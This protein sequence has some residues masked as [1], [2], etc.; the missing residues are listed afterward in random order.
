MPRKLLLIWILVFA[1]FQTQ[2]QNYTPVPGDV[3]GYTSGSFNVTDAGAATYSVPFNFSPGSAGFQPSV[4]MTYSSQ[5]GNGLLGLGWSLQGFSVISRAS[6]TLAQDNQIKGVSFST[7]DRFA[8]DGERLILTDPTNTYGGNGVE[9]RT[10]QNA[11][12]KII[13]FGSSNVP[14]SFKVYTNSGLTIDY[15][16]TSDTRVELAGKTIFWLV[17]KITDTKGNYYTFSYYK[18]NTTGE[19][20]PL[21]IKYTGNTTATVLPYA[22]I[23]FEYED[24]T[25]TTIQYNND[26]KIVGN[27]KRIKTIKNYF[28]NIL[29]R[30]YAFSYQYTNGKISQLNSL[31]ECG[32]NNQCHT[33][34][35]F[36]YTN[37]ET[38]AF[39]SSDVTNIQQSS[40]QEKIFTADIDADG[41]Q[42]ILKINPGNNLSGFTSNKSPSNLTFSA[43]SFSPA[44]FIADKFS[45]ADFNGDGKQDILTYSSSTGGNTLFINKT[46]SDD[47][48]IK[49]NS[50]G[51]AVPSSILS[52]NK[53]IAT[54]DFNGDGRSDILSY[55]PAT[56]I[57]NWMFSLTVGNTG[58]SFLKVS[59]DSVFTN[60]LPTAVFQNNQQATF[61]D[62]NGDGL[63]DAFILNPANG[64]NEIYYNNGGNP[65]SFTSA[66]S[67]KI[68]PS[69]LLAAGARLSIQDMNGDRLPDFLVYIKSTGATHWWLNLGNS[70]F[71]KVNA[72]P[73]NL[74]TSITSGDNLLQTDFNGD[75][76]AD[77]IWIDKT[78][79]TN[80]WFTNDGKLNFTQ[81]TG[82][83]INTSDLQNYD[84]NGAGNFSSKSNLELFVFNNTANPKVKIIRCEQKYNNLLSRINV[85][86]GQQIDIAYD[87]LTSDSLYTKSDNSVY[88]LMDY[89][90]SQF[91]VKNYKVNNGVGDS[92][93]VSYHYKG[94]KLHLEGRGFRGFTQVD[95][96]DD[97]TGITQSKYYLDDL[98][99]WKYINSPLVKS[100][101]RLPNN[102]VISETDIENGLKVFYG[103]KCHYSYVKKNVSKSYE[104]DGSFVDS[105]VTTQ[106]YDDY[107]NVIS[108][109]TK[110]GSGS[111]DSLINVFHNNS[112]TWILS[113]L[114]YSKLYRIAPNKP[115][116]IKTSSFDY[117]STNG[118][119]LL[120]AETIEP[121]AGNTIKI[122]KTYQHDAFG[123][124]IKSSVSA[125]NGTAI[126]TRTTNSA[127]DS[128]GRFTVS[129][130]NGIG[131]I[132]KSS[133]DPYLG[134]VLN[135]TDINNLVTKYTYDG[136]GRLT[137]TTSPDGNWSSADYRKCSSSFACPSL[138]THLIYTQSSTGPPVIKYF[139]LLDREIRTER[140]GFNGS[141]IYTDAVYDNRGLVVKQSLPYYSTD[142]AIYTRFQYDIVGRNTV[143]VSPGN[144]FD[145]IKYQGRTT[146]S[147]NSLGQ[148]KVLIK[149]AKEQLIVSKD[150][151]G[152]EIA[153]DYDAAGRLLT[154][155][156]PDGNVITKKYDVH[157]NITEQIDPDMGSFKYVTNGFGELISQTDAKNQIVS[158][159]YDSLSRLVKRAEPEGV[160]IWTYDTQPNGKG[161]LD[162]VSSYNFNKTAY[163]YDAFSRVSTYSQRIDSQ[164]YTHSYTY[165]VL[166]R[167]A[168]TVYPSGFSTTNVYNANGYLFQVKNTSTN[169]VYW[170]ASKLNAKDEVEEQTYGNG[171]TINKA[172]DPLTDFLTKVTTKKG[173]SVLQDLT[174]SYN[175]LG[176][177]V[178]RKDNLQNKQE[179]FWYDNLNRLTK[180]KV[181]GQDS[182][183]IQYDKLGNITMKS[184]VG[185]YA[186]GGINAGPH[187]V[188]T[189]NLTTA[190]CVP[191]LLI[192]HQ[193]NSFNKIRE[194]TKDSFKVDI[195]Y[196]ID[197]MRNVQKM[198]SN[199]NLV[200]TKIYVS[201]LFEKEIKGGDTITTNYIHGGGGVI[202]TYTT[203]SKG[204]KTALQYFHRDHLGS[205]V[206]VTNDT[207]A[208]MAR[209][210]FDAWGKRRNADWSSTLTDTLG[211]A[212]DRGFTGHEHYDLFDLV[213]MNGRIYDPVIGRFTSP[214]PYIQDITNLQSLN[215]Y[216]Y[217]LNCP[218]SYTDPSGYWNVFKAIKSVFKGIGNVVSKAVEWVGDN[219]RQIATTIITIAVGSFT[220]GGGIVLSG[221]ATGFASTVTGTL[222]AGGNI[223][224]AFKA[225]I[226]GA[227]IGGITAQL[228]F[229][230]GEYV[231]NPFERAIA[232]GL[233]Q[234]G[235]SSAEGGKFIHGFYSGAL[236]AG[237]S[238][239]RQLNFTSRTSRV[240]AASVTGGTASELSGGKFANG[241][242]SGAFIQMYNDDKHPPLNGNSDDIHTALDISG[243]TPFAGIYADV[244]N[245]ILYI[246]EGDFFNAGV[247][248]LGMAPGGQVATGARVISKGVKFTGDQQALITLAKEAK[249]IGVTLDEAKILKSWGKEYNINVRG[250]EI[251]PNRNFKDRH[252]HVGPVDHIK[253]KE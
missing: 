36:T 214:D 227:V 197:R 49:T 38:P 47:I 132:S 126:E 144:R 141:T 67:N 65:I 24:R 213:D 69:I 74:N 184:D 138:A 225:G 207:G 119:G 252:I 169:A 54:I 120:I 189:I 131:Q 82:T 215:R 248:V 181:F 90:A 109:V 78:T 222:L 114:R 75:G 116:I 183:V 165:D 175:A 198:Y 171:T 210:S 136:L 28:N 122:R 239:W 135:D 220:A 105:T 113:R 155:T 133:Y 244:T 176:I 211:L 164:I 179:D 104:L 103:G 60:R 86:N 247:S 21:E 123:N 147:I 168:T 124:I 17:E 73:S 250:P 96:T 97:N 192:S 191:S 85:G 162:S 157:G 178:Q 196:N 166:G 224:D 63:T 98:N 35:T 238:D 190:Q 153:Y 57:N 87:F 5:G 48:Q 32:M 52:G 62:L 94:A 6:Q 100:V 206:L 23:Q 209:Y 45:F 29:V 151:Q 93:Q 112:N 143:T 167:P 31:K 12:Y 208:V 137:K 231:K 146:T 201:A 3:S 107:G 95:V 81:L 187:Q 55:D 20:Y 160:T 76:F 59:T 39:S 159:E 41:V 149:D 15:G 118:T 221:A 77:L 142:T 92:S 152:N 241:A 80:K 33:P 245:A 127:M 172:F 217:V 130:T 83:I 219:W 236:V 58:L 25:D 193:F 156:D 9:Y 228:T 150:E 68:T 218:L 125:W 174:H 229:G 235:A 129:L 242:V 134:H 194:I 44:I 226:K 26:F 4:S 8:L 200:R 84:F 158:L 102:V 212:A 108:S 154:I 163:T 195:S 148:K 177:L 1:I 223:G 7:A 203:H 79:G 243:L 72:L 205:T 170:T 185:T 101:T 233:V 188:K 70:I 99:C 89:Q 43:L 11:F 46:L 186:Y 117:D 182:V 121:D 13:S 40:S 2:A 251:H 27:S 253:V 51:A 240:I 61:A 14:S 180:S 249:R 111:M 110:Y 106:E 37:I 140:K 115:T 30:S 237:T 18:N 56:G 161:L 88:P 173:S 204:A 34:T 232:H 202:G 234:G 50:A 145:S 10:E 199:G 216:S 66:G 128:F 139:D 42:D 246:S 230:V 16:A 22:S 91:A 19:Y 64:N 71:T 53:I